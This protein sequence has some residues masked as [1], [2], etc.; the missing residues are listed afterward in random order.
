MWSLV[1]AVYA[2]Y[3]EQEAERGSSFQLVLQYQDN[4][5]SW[6]LQLVATGN[7]RLCTKASLGTPTAW[8]A[9]A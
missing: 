9:A 8:Q 4:C 5:N 3:W 7:L 1:G 6:K 2:P